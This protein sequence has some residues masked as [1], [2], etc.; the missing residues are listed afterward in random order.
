MDRNDP[1]CRQ[2]LIA[3]EGIYKE[4][5]DLALPYLGVR[6]NDLHTRIACSFAIRLLRTEKAKEQV[7]LP[8]IL[9]HD[10]G[11]SQLT[12][13]EINAA[14]GPDLKDKTY[15]RMHEMEGARLAR[16]LLEGRGF[17]E[18]EV[19]AI[20]AIID[21]HDSRLVTISPEDALVKDADKLFRYTRSGVDFVLRWTGLGRGAYLRWL[22]EQI[23]TCFFTASAKTIAREHLSKR[24]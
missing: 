10:I 13:E 9:L 16:Q 1:D 7:V 18:P 21:G 4:L 15:Q 17:C 8:A 14:F 2:P 23:P 3:P 11:Y 6:E 20:C 19:E 5:L 24:V 22:E 12:D